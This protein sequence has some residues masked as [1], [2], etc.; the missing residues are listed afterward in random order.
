MSISSIHFN[1]Q[2]LG[3][4]IVFKFSLKVFFTRITYIFSRW[5]LINYNTNFRSD[6]NNFKCPVFEELL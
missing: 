3:Q 6:I 2:L 1:T 4:V 5:Q